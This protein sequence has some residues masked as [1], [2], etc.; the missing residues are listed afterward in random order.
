MNPRLFS[1]AGSDG[2]AWKVTSNSAICGEPLPDVISVSVIAGDVA[3]PA[4]AAWLLHGVTS[5]E[6]Y[7]IRD[8]KTL[9]VSKQQG[10]ARPE[11]GCAAMIPIRKNDAWWALSQ[12]QRRMILEEQSEHIK[13]GM[14]YLPAIARKL[15][16]CRDLSTAEPFDFVT[17]FEFAPEHAAAFD[18]LLAELRGS[19]EWRYVDREVDIRMLRS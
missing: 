17:W 8:E 1:F 19:P 7:V 13:I 12:D 15:H 11:A 5:N 14:K 16:H 2:G 4:N 10:L 18:D 6:R 3:A 9:L